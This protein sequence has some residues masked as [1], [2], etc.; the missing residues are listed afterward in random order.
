MNTVQRIAK[1]I[2]ALFT[3]QFV[4]SIHGSGTKMSF[5]KG[6]FVTL[7][8]Q[9]VVL[10]FNLIASIILARALGPEGRGIF[11][12]LL[13]IPA[14]VITFTGFNI[15][16]ANVYLIN[17]EKLSLK[18]IIK[19][20]Y[21]LLTV[22]GAL[23]FIISILLF[24]IWPDTV[25]K[26]IDQRDAIIASSIVFSLLFVAY[27][28]A[29]VLAF[30]KILQYN[31]VTFIS[32]FTKVFLLLV[33]LYKLHLGI[34]GALTATLTAGIL[35]CIIVRRKVNDILRE[36]F[37]SQDYLDNEGRHAVGVMKKLVI[38][39]GRAN[40]SN[41]LWYLVLRSDMF[42][43]SVFLGIEALGYYAVAVGVAEQLRL[44][45]TTIGM[46]LFP[47]ASSMNDADKIKFIGKVTRY[48]FWV[49]LL[50]SIPLIIFGDIL[51]RVLFSQAFLPVTN[52]FR[53]L[54]LAI[55]M[56][57]IYNI[58]SYEFITSG[59]PEINIYFNGI[60]LAM[61]L[62][63]NFFLIPK[64]GIGGAAVA[65]LA[66]YSLISTLTVI[67]ISRTRHMNF[68]KFLLPQKGDWA[69]IRALAHDFVA[70]GVKA[71]KI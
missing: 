11:A 44:I 10:L 13:L 58:L 60:G 46:V 30:Q 56:L 31:I 1:N 53:I 24:K 16:A 54:L 7:A 14:T 15:G 8:T 65:S 38:F 25:A 36:K 12:L 39:G 52:A 42:L 71:W 62:G 17:R 20:N 67:A 32:T 43:V 41:I 5:T 27:F 22:I 33:L 29:I 35:S 28:N 9:I 49:V 4:T 34:L 55:A 23:S 18:E 45:P 63:L 6:V 2:A 68:A 3:A 57:S 21:V 40:L 61:N 66:A 64:Y 51:I 19:A 59:K 47:K 50:L 26:Q 70:S 48:S 37:S 69:N